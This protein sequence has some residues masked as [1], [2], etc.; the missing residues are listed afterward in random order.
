M[1]RKRFLTLLGSTPLLAVATKAAASHTREPRP[2]SFGHENVLGTSLELKFRAASRL[3]AGRAEAAALAE[4]D[5]LNRTLSAFD[6]G[7]EFRQW[8]RGDGRPQPVSGD[9]FHILSQFD[10]WRGQTGG[11][12]NAG[13]ETVNRVWRRAASEGR[14]PAEAEVASAVA[15]ASGPH[16]TLDAGARTAA[17]RSDAALALHSF[18]KSYIV[19]RAA[20][21]AL[22]SGADGAVVNIGGDLVVRG[23]WTEAVAIADPRSD[24]ENG[25]RLATL[26]VADSAVATSGSYRRGVEIAGLHYSHIV[27]PRTGRPAD[28]V[29]SS[30]VV[31]P[32]ATDAGALATAFSVLPGEESRRLAES[33]PGVEYLLV[34]KD[35]SQMASRGWSRLA[36]SMAAAQAGPGGW[37]GSMELLVQFELARVQDQRYRRPFVAVWIEDKDRFPVRTIALWFDKPRWLPDLRAWSRADRMRGMAEGTDITASV[38]SATRPPGKYSVKWDGKDQQGKYVKPGTY[39]VL[40]EAAREHGTYQ[41]LR[42]EME[43]TGK[44]KQVQVAGNIE[45]AS[46]S[47]DYRKAAR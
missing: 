32:S 40:I 14:M 23:D 13:A 3:H 12:L 6:S 33:R 1:H 41:L 7:S 42:Q 39:T 30:T 5:R 4:I 31:A 2:Y 34:S 24:E 10:H 43:F 15:T 16:W 9:L 36:M 38:S 29:L 21:A 28:H 19:D 27:D 17:R 47:L 22:Q 18:A 35:G 37:D 45:I 25:A 26:R 20:E 44:P 11:A 46:A 8:L